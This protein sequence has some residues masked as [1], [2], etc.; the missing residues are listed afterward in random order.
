[1]WAGVKECWVLS[2]EV[3]FG[4]DAPWLQG[5]FSR[6]LHHSLCRA[7][8]CRSLQLPILGATR[9]RLI[10][11]SV[12]SLWLSVGDRPCVCRRSQGVEAWIRAAGQRKKIPGRAGSRGSGWHLLSDH[13]LPCLA[14]AGACKKERKK[15]TSLSH[16][17]IF[18][19]PWTVAC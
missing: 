17:Q 7:A 1:M 19:T 18:A 6:D 12:G 13:D 2:S 4:P 14:Q 10:S 3:A 9:Q 15:V 8:P 5:V 16:V 11:I